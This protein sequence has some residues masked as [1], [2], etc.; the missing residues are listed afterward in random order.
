MQMTT[1]FQREFESEQKGLWELTIQRTKNHIK[2]ASGTSNPEMAAVCSHHWPTVSRAHS[3]PSRLLR[4]NLRHH[5]ISSLDTFIF[6]LKDGGFFK[7][8]LKRLNLGAILT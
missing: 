1:E 2:Q 5:R 3:A 4:G 7:N 6:S 8:N